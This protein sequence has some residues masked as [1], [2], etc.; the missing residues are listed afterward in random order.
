MVG[1]P[2]TGR[3]TSPIVAKLTLRARNVK[4]SQVPPASSREARFPTL[5]GKV[6]VKNVAAS[7][8]GSINLAGRMERRGI[9]LALV[10]LLDNLPGQ[11]FGQPYRIT[12]EF[13]VN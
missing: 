6:G 7:L 11:H 8:T 13:W 2:L 3:R 10:I 12:R 4:L 9:W 1:L 5:R